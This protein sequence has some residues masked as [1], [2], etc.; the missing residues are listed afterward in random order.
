ML[1]R[2][3]TKI[4]CTL[5]PSTSSVTKIKQLIKSGMSVARLNLSHGN[6]SEHKK[7]IKNA[8]LASKELKF[9]LA[10]LADIPGPKYRIG[11][12]NSGEY[13]ELVKGSE[14]IFENQTNSENIN[15]WPNGFTNNLKVGSKILVDEGSIEMRLLS[16]KGNTINCKVTSGGKLQSNKEKKVLNLRRY[17]VKILNETLV[18][19]NKFI[20]N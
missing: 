12:L 14:I 17:G 1:N 19:I 6:N 2:P 11:K 10:I 8:R 20:K 7:L 3:K 18:E 15:I 5:G 16:V 9:P 4:V 13:L